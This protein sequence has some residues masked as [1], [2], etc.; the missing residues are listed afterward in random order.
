MGA[1]IKKWFHLLLIFVFAYLAGSLAGQAT[2][3]VLSSDASSQNAI[4]E[5]TMPEPSQK[6]VALTEN[7]IPIYSAS[8]DGN[9]GLSF[10]TPGKLP[11]EIQQMTI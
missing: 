1:F 11:L 4:P 2:N 8:A 10:P 6:P 5:N 7:G 9:W 3:R